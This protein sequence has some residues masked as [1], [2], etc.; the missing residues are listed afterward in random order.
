MDRHPPRRPETPNARKWPGISYF[1][2]FATDRNP[3]LLAGTWHESPLLGLAEPTEEDLRRLHT[4]TVA[5]KEWVLVADFP[6]Q[7]QNDNKRSQQVGG[8]HE[9]SPMPI[10]AEF[11][12]TCRRWDCPLSNLRTYGRARRMAS[13][14]AARAS[15]TR[16]K[17]LQTMW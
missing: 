2:S 9:T 16:V 10:P 3:A 17:S 5:E 14:P 13:A 11:R 15:S 6:R 4:N 8:R 12:G 7:R 1:P